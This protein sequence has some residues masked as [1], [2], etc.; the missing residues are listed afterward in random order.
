M[1]K[2]LKTEN[3]FKDS[4]V[5]TNFICGV[6]FP[7]KPSVDRDIALVVN[8]FNWSII[9]LKDLMIFSKNAKLRLLDVFKTN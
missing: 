6:I 8:W 9:H 7:S 5:L 4:V 2:F 1:N 3:I